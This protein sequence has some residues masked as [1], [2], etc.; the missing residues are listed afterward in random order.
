MYEKISRTRESKDIHRDTEEKAL[1]KTKMQISTYKKS[2]LEVRIQSYVGKNPKVITFGFWKKRPIF[3][4]KYL[5][6]NIGRA[7]ATRRLR[8][9]SRF[10]IDI[11]RITPEYV[12]KHSDRYPYNPPHE[13]LLIGGFFLVFESTKSL[14]KFDI[15][16][17]THT[18]YFK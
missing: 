18:L 5:E 12:H 4:E 1:L 11:K 7:D 14:E 2:Q 13:S 8:L 6:A 3:L 15:C 16:L 10:I 9:F 17:E